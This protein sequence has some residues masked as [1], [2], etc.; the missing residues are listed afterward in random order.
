MNVKSLILSIA[1][2]GSLS[3]FAAATSLPFND[4]VTYKIGKRVESQPSWLVPEGAKF[5]SI[6]RGYGGLKILL[7]VIGTV[8]CFSVMVIA[9]KELTIEPFR[10]KLYEF[11][12]A[13]DTAFEM[14]LIEMKKKKLLEASEVDFE[15]QIF[16]SL[17]Y[18]N[19]Q[20][21]LTGTQTLNSIAHPGDKIENS[22]RPPI[23]VA[24]T[25]ESIDTFG[26]GEINKPEIAPGL[27]HPSEAKA[28]PILRRL[29]SSRKSLLNI[30]GTGGG[31]TVTQ[32]CLIS[33]LMVACPKVEFFGVSQKNDSYCGLREKGRITIFDITNVQSTLDVIHHVWTIYDTRRMLPEEKRANLSPVRLLLGDWFSISLA[34]NELSSHPAVKASKYLVEMVDIVLNGRDFNV[35]LWADLQSFN[36]EAIG[37][38]TDKN[39]RQNFNLLG[40]GNYYTNDEG[41]NESY[42]VLNNMINDHFMVPNKETRI[43]L[44]NEFE[45]LKP[46]SMK[47]QRPILFVTLEPPTICLQAD[48]RHYQQQYQTPSNGVSDAQIDIS[49][50]SSKKDVALPEQDDGNSPNAYRK[51]VEGLEGLEVRDSSEALNQSLN[52]FLAEVINESLPP[53]FADDFPLKKHD[54]RVELAK[55]V[56]ARNLGKQK[57]IWLLWGVRDGGRNNQRYIDAREMLDRLIKGENN[58]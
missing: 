52:G 42:G 5:K 56:I 6:E 8:G 41:V 15:N 1:L 57:T 32:S 44:L 31:K 26:V 17:G 14:A 23:L 13:A 36:L 21:L 54:R 30:A 12:L 53:V 9:R 20:P 27:L 16:R 19:P 43:Q 49:D 33:L 39:S 2:I 28:L 29:A 51:G 47:H 50:N 48:I 40:L 11:K 34:L 18:N 24:N 10:Q 58:D 7:S 45:Q 55:L 38:K 4:Q 3:S 25:N 35:C 37:M 46:V 22:N